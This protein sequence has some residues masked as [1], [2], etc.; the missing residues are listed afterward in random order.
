MRKLKWKCW[1]N[2]IEE[3]DNT[4]TWGNTY[5]ILKQKI[6]PRLDNNIPFIDN[7]TQN[8]SDALK[9]LMDLMFPNDETPTYSPNHSSYNNDTTISFQAEELESII[10]SLN[11][12]KAPGLDFISNHMIAASFPTINTF[13]L[14]L[15]NR[16]LSLKYFPIKWKKS[17]VSI[18]K[19]PNKDLNTSG[20]YRPI[21]LSSN[22]SKVFEKLLNRKITYHVNDKLSPYQYGFRQNKSTINALDHIFKTAIEFKA[23]GPAAILAIDL[24]AAFDN[25]S[26]SSIISGMQLLQ[27]PNQLVATIQNFLEDR[28]IVTKY[29]DTSVEKCTSKGCPQGSPL[30]PTLWNIALNSLLNIDEL[31]NTNTQLVVFADDIT[32]IIKESTIVRLRKRTTECILAIDKWCTSNHL[33][34]NYDK[35]QI[36]ALHRPPIMAPIEKNEKLIKYHLNVKILGVTFGNHAFRNRLNVSQHVTNVVSKV[37]KIKNILF[38]LHGNT[39]GIDSKKRIHLYKSLIRPSITYGSEIWL[40]QCTSKN[41]STLNSLQYQILR[42]A[43]KTFKYTSQACVE[44]LSGTPSIQSHLRN[45]QSIYNNRS[46][47]QQPTTSLKELDRESLAQSYEGTNSVFKEFVVSPS[48][49][50]FFRNSFFSNQLITN[51]GR[52]KHYFRKLRLESSDQCE[53]NTGGIQDGR[54]LTTSCCLFTPLQR[55]ETPSDYLKDKTSLN[56]LDA[57]AKSIYFSYPIPTITNLPQ[58]RT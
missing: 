39:W 48:L 21:C 53:C 40:P 43:T 1:L 7:N 35:S 27:T 6:N 4:N 33:S 54:H 18:L 10:N 2:F 41:L 25:V 23:Q 19:K 55:L 34:I 37:T 11:F 12:K 56:L 57:I 24:K 47:N 20:A 30:S 14:K 16:C 51:S 49:P 50:K 52:N 42:R 46:L 9:E 22:L 5:K 58:T 13:L 8:R 32:V 36:L 28:L 31:N 17:Y 26:W 29:S 45:K 3:N 15:F 44:V 38:G